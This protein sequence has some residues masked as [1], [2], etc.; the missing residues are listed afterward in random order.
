VSSVI[1]L[2]WPKSEPDGIP[3]DGIQGDPGLFAFVWLFCLFFW[4]V[5]D[6]LK[7]LVYWYMYKIN[8]NGI[9]T[10]GVV[11]LP[12]SAKELGKVVDDAVQ[13]AGSVRGH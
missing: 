12:E 13:K 6:A 4:Y 10:S 7:V 5:Q 8:F 2:F 1:A 11:V 9:D 3:F